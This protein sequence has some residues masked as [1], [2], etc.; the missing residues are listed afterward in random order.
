MIF[1]KRIFIVGRLTSRINIALSSGSTGVWL[2]GVW[3]GGAPVGAADVAHAAVGV[4][5][6]LGLAAGDGVGG[7]GE[8]GHT[9]ALG[10]TVPVTIRLKIS[11]ADKC[12]LLTV[13]VVPGPQGEG[14]QG[15]PGG[16]G[17]TLR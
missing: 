13:Q 6:T 2:T 16:G 5:H 1:I 10:V 8:P 4:N 3:L 15:L 12:Y 14:T 11:Q 17:P 9:A 7:G